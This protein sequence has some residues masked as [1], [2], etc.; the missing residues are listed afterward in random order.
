[1]KSTNRV[2]GSLVVAVA[3]SAA[4]VTAPVASGHA[5]AEGAG[6]APLPA[7]PPSACDAGAISAGVGQQL[8]VLRCY[9]GWAYVTNGELG[10]STSLVRTVGSNWTFYAGF[11]SSLCKAQAASDG[12]P[13]P[14]LSSFTRC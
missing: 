13:E 11:P 14:E 7:A 12:V 3:C 2:L 4:M 9:P 8:Q 6:L 1:M 5:F 10:D